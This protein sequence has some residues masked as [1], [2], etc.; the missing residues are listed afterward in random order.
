LIHIPLSS[1]LC[2]WQIQAQHGLDRVGVTDDATI[3]ALPV[4]HTSRTVENIS[5]HKHSVAMTYEYDTKTSYTLELF[6]QAGKDE[7]VHVNKT[8]EMNYHRGSALLDAGFFC[9]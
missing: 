2:P 4:S 5:I 9:E 8:I 3:E 1:D 7:I 6:Y